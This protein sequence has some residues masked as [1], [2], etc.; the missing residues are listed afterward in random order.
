MEKVEEGRM[1]Y[2]CGGEADL[3]GGLIRPPV[4]RVSPTKYVKY[5]PFD[6]ILYATISAQKTTLIPHD[7]FI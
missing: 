2:F 5:C 3:V 6:D 4:T 7:T 1:P